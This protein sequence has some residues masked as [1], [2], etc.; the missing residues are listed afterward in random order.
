MLFP[1]QHV[2]TFHFYHHNFFFFFYFPFHY[3]PTIFIILCLLYESCSDT[4]CWSIDCALF[5]ISL[6]E[7]NPISNEQISSCRN[8]HICCKY[9]HFYRM[10]YSSLYTTH[11]A[12]IMEIWFYTQYVNYY[13]R[14]LLFGLHCNFIFRIS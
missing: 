1:S 13:S 8:L 4:Y 7:S 2:L 11:C 12:Y 9:C 6:Y 5:N 10:M 14:C 3:L